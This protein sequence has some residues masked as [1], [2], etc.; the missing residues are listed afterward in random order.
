MREILQVNPMD[1]TS[2]GVIKNLLGGYKSI[3][4][5]IQKKYKDLVWL[6]NELTTGFKYVKHYYPNY[7]IPKV[8]TF[9][10]TLDAPGVVL[11]PDYLGIGLHQY[12]GKNFS[13]YQVPQVQEMYPAYISRR[14]DKEYITANCMKAIADDIYPDKSPGKPLIEQMIEKGKQWFLLDKFLP[15]APDSVKTGFSKKQ[16]DCT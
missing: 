2:F 10:A 13:V 14:F 1:T 6:K 15:D 8:I 3:N 5:S 4:D 16:L 11:T 9:I 7:K 12:A